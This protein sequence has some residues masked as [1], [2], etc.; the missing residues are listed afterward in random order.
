[1]K[2][3]LRLQGRCDFPGKAGLSGL[4]LSNTGRCGCLLIHLSGRRGWR[5]LRVSCPSGDHVAQALLQGHLLVWRC[6]HP[7]QAVWGG[8]SCHQPQGRPQP[9]SW[10]LGLRGR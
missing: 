1:M 8:G 4:F 2:I 10:V 6:P 9:F 5:S 7:F 3:L